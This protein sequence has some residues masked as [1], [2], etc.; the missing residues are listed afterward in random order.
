MFARMTPFH[1][2]TL[3]VFIAL[4]LPALLAEGMFMDGLLYTCVARNLGEGLGTFWQPYFSA[5]WS[6][7]DVNS[8]HEHPP[9]AFGIQAVLYRLLGDSIYVERGYSLLCALA[10]AGFLSAIW[11]RLFSSLEEAELYWLPILCWIGVPVVFWSF[12]NNMQENTL[13]VF[14]LA[15]CY[16]GYSYGRPEG[17]TYGGLLLAGIS[18]FAASLTKGL[19]GLFPLAIPFFDYL[20][21]RHD[22]FGRMLGRSL[23]LLTVPVLLY[24]LLATIPVA[25]E[26][27]WFYLKFRLLSRIEVAPTVDSRWFSLSQTVLELL[28][29]LIFSLLSLLI[30]RY[31]KPT[32]ARPVG[33]S[34][35][36]LF[37]TALGLSGVLPLLLTM[38]Q[39]GF[40]LVP[41]FPFFALALALLASTPWRH[42]TNGLRRSPRA[43][44]W[45]LGLAWALVL[46]S[47]GASTL[48]LGTVKRD[49]DLIEA[50][51][52]MGE[53]VGPHQTIRIEPVLHERWSLHCY[54]M[55]Y[56][57][58][59]LDRKPID[60]SYYLLR[61][62]VEPVADGYRA[63]DLP[64]VRG[65]TLY[66]ALAAQRFSK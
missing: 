38:V 16:W 33:W 49:R 11:R 53:R 31:G 17:P 15:A 59:S 48:A 3:A 39:K 19:P 44:G 4:L 45:G 34:R 2:L 12:Q 18:I 35:H 14:V 40:Y 7:W 43:Y 46:L 25:R 28:P 58:I 32:V 47:V 30:H 13:S 22:S 24:G 9:L 61:E 52:L 64:A 63:V 56:Y 29:A 26:S 51:K 54:F 27:L 23:L 50:V 8:F 5:T 42:W 1:L 36:L 57:H 66:E 60:R 21:H 10:S 6:K 37:F 62:G 20:V 65:Y 55:R 41:A